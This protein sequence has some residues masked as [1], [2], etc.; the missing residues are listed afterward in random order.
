MSLLTSLG[1]AGG[2]AGAADFLQE[3][4][5]LAIRT[6]MADKKNEFLKLGILKASNNFME[7]I[8][9]RITRGRFF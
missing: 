3:K 7:K 8:T 5:A 9:V 2:M 4:H 6:V 1:V